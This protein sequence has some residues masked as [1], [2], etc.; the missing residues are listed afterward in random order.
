MAL[1]L[2]ALGLATLPFVGRWSFLVNGWARLTGDASVYAVGAGS[3]EWAHR[4]VFLLLFLVAGSLVWATDRWLSLLV[5]F[6]GMQTFVMGPR[7]V[8]AYFLMGIGAL[9]L[10]RRVDA[11]ARSRALAWIGWAGLAQSLVVVTQRWKGLDPVGSFGVTGLAGGSIALTGFLAPSWTLPVAAVGVTL[12][13]SR[14]ALLAF[15][16]GLGVRYLPVM[17]LTIAAVIAAFLV[18]IALMVWQS[19]TS[20]SARATVHRLML[21]DWRASTG[22]IVWGYGLGSWAQRVQAVQ[23][24]SPDSRDLAKDAAGVPAYRYFVS[25]HSDPIQWVYETGLLGSAL[26][27]FWLARWRAMFLLPRVAPALT[28]AAVLSLAWFPLHDLRLGML[29]AAL[30][31]AGTSTF[32]EGA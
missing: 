19:P 3:D 6:A 20:A 21:N 22:A 12:T 27:V 2:L 11:A 16:V 31:G 25:A 14:A 23:D 4:F 1:V 10:M 26:L 28:V 7:V 29:T 9:V 5:G 18:C 17:P 15:L 24:A 32:A 30:V 13:G 8:S